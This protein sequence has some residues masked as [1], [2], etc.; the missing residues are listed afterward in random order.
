MLHPDIQRHVVEDL[1]KKLPPPDPQVLKRLDLCAQAYGVCSN[2]G[3]LLT[4]LA[5]VF[6]PAVA[7]PIAASPAMQLSPAET[8]IY[9]AG[10]QS[11]LAYLF[12]LSNTHRTHRETKTNV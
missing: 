3:I 10:Q 6:N 11:A 5:T 9:R 8:M 12:Q 7:P 1:A 4:H 2:Y